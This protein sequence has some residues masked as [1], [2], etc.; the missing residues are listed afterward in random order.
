MTKTDPPQGD[1][2]TKDFADLARDAA[3][4]TETAD[5]TLPAPTAHISIEGYEIIRELHRGGQGVVY[6]ALQRSTKRKVA[7]KLLLR[8]TLASDKA[9]KRFEREIELVAQLKHPHIISIFHSGV[10]SDCHPFFVMEYVRG[11]RLDKY[12]REKRL[13]LEATLELFSTVCGGVQYAHQRGV[14]H[15]DLK[16]SNILVDADGNPKILDFGLAKLLAGPIDAVVSI[17]RDVLGTLPYMSPEQARGNPDEIDA[18][19]DVYSLGVILYELL[20]G[21]F[22]YPVVGQVADVLRH[23]VET[24]PSPPTRKWTPD[25]GIARREGT[26][27]PLGECPID[28]EVE[29]IVLKALAK[30]RER[31]YQ[32]AADVAHDIDLYLRGEPIEARRDSVVYVLRTRCRAFAQRHRITSFLAVIVISMLLAQYIGVPLIFRWTPANEFFERFVTGAVSLSVSGP[33]FD[34]VRIIGLTDNTDVEDIA[35][36]EGL[37]NVTIKNIKSWRR[38]HGR[39][40]EKLAASRCR[41]VVWDI[42]FR[43]ETEFDGGFVRGVRALR[44]VGVDVVVGVR[45]WQAIGGGSPDL[46]RTIARSGVRWGCVVLRFGEDTPPTL[47]AAAQRGLADPQPSLALAAVASY[48]HPGKK[49]DIVLDP[50][51]E[52]ADLRY[53]TSDTA[54]PQAKRWLV[55]DHIPLTAAHIGDAESGAFEGAVASEFDLRHDDLVGFYLFEV[56]PDSVLSASTIEYEQVFSADEEQLQQWFGDKAIIIGNF[57]RSAGDRYRLADGR[58]LSPCYGHAAAIDALLR[59]VF[60]RM[61]RVTGEFVIPLVGA[62]LGCITAFLIAGGA[63]RR[64]LAMAVLTAVF[65]AVSVIAYWQFQYLFNPLVPVLALL[66]AGEMSAAVHRVVTSRRG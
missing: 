41:T 39:L 26:R 33:V 46:S 24:P 1:H 32:T 18:R 62:L 19:I 54:I 57:R 22:P 64:Y 50:R 12:V 49:F 53:W 3:A 2:G 65:L 7:I 47:Q 28:G 40:M 30:E 42:T 9:R 17:T 60:V 43:R 58:I 63:L 10:T 45:T 14:V 5:V 35:R 4:E 37:E 20:T 52:S 11:L 16:P 13:T 31:R 29:T 34:A 6:E 66:V 61:P 59:K 48:R 36:R 15:R 21:H 23:V 8:G 25:S 44:D 55:S 51:T 27:A 38:L 56:P